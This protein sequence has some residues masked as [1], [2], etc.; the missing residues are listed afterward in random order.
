MLMESTTGGTMVTTDVIP[1]SPQ[2]HPSNKKKR[3]QKKY[4]RS[5]YA[6]RAFR[7]GASGRLTNTPGDL[8]ERQR[9]WSL[10]QSHSVRL[11]VQG[12]CRGIIPLST[13]KFELSHGSTAFS[14]GPSKSNVPSSAK[15]TSLYRL[16]DIGGVGD[17]PRDSGVTSTRH[18]HIHPNV[19]RP[20]WMN[21]SQVANDVLSRRRPIAPC[22]ARAAS[23]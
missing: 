19:Q 16:L 5:E 10:G 22:S 15:L 18:I 17:G 12:T 2:S 3:P 21:G 11:G 8:S 4:Y 9:G 6:Y 7:K 1:T 14:A 13:G 23:R 20:T